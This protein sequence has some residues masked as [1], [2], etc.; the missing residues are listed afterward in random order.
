M[1]FNIYRVPALVLII[2]FLTANAGAFAQSC[3]G[4]PPP[5]PSGAT[6]AHG[7]A[8][9]QN[10]APV[11]NGTW[12]LFGMAVLYGTWKIYHIKKANRANS[13]DIV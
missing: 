5:P 11:G 12:L 4:T 2:V 1:K 6:T 7:S 3:E 10:Q 13:P 9:S 8:P